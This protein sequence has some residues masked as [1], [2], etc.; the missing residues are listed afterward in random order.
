MTNKK[1]CLL[2][3]PNLR[4]VTKLKGWILGDFRFSTGRLRLCFG[5]SLLGWLSFGFA[6]IEASPLPSPELA[7]KTPSVAQTPLAQKMSLSEED[8]LQQV[9]NSSPYLLKIKATQQKRLSQ[10]LEQ[11]YS[12][13]DWGLTSS[14]KEE[15]QN[16][17]EID[18]FL[19]KEKSSKVW[20]LALQKQWP[21]GLQ[22]YSSYLNTAEQNLDTDELFKRFRPSNIYRN[23]SQLGLKYNLTQSVTHTWL[24]KSFPLSLSL[25]DLIHLE[26]TEELALKALE[27]YWKTRIAWVSWQKAQ[28]GLKTYKKLVRQ[29]HNKQK[30]NFLQPG[31]RP[32]ILAEYQNIQ[33]IVDQSQQNYETEKKALLVFL[34]PKH[35][36][37][38]WDFKPQK[39]QAP[40]KLSKIN[41]EKT[42]TI[43]IQNQQLEIQKLQLLA[44]KSS[45][46]P[47]VEFEGLRGWTPTSKSPQLQLV[48]DLSFYEFGVQFKW[49]LFSKSA[50]QK[51]HQKK[52]ELEENKIDFAIAKHQL[53]NQIDLLEKQ[54]P[55]AYKDIERTK[56]AI[57]YYKQAFKEIQQSFEQGRVDVFQLIQI[58]KQVRN[59]QLEHAVALSQ[60]S[61]SLAGLLA[62]KD[63]LLEKYI[64]P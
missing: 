29:I 40:H 9:L 26:K 51:I 28:E 54:I 35:T 6:Q 15:N 19:P 59:S 43:L 46:F 36:F 58:E 7:Q 18:P 49:V 42:R 45:L 24:F 5:L 3:L 30:Y 27:Q 31:E 41:I 60:Y 38:E 4:T 55:L 22:F 23:R 12:F 44:Q 57:Q 34:K 48:S 52:Y 47:K 53:K 37:P 10:I 39:I 21:Y 8:F 61:L 63:K 64:T 17:S 32:Q 11:K 2:V 14:W 25:N 13:F 33:K 16:N 56:K 50:Y 20:S 1:R 62:L